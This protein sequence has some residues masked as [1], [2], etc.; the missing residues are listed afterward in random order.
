MPQSLPYDSLDVRRI[1]VSASTSGDNTILAAVT[2]KRI[3]LIAAA[4]TVAGAVNAKW[5][6]STAGDLSGVYVLSASGDGIVLPYNP[7]GWVETVAGEALEL[8][9]SGAVAV[10]GHVTVMVGD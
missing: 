6:S 5:Q 2:G 8:N 10:T 9:L 7:A 3:R 1:A 4:L